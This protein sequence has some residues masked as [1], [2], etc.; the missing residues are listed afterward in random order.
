MSFGVDGGSLWLSN[1]KL[2][3]LRRAKLLFELRLLSCR[4]N[5]FMNDYF[6]IL[7][8]QCSLIIQKKEGRFV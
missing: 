5:L 3:M 1:D 8:K 7:I 4:M 2:R 6:S